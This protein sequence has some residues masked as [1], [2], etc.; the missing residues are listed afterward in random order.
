MSP[1]VTQSTFRQ[2]IVKIAGSGHR[3]VI[4]SL[5]AQGSIEKDTSPVPEVDE[6]MTWK[7][8]ASR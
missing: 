4:V 3:I 6:R 8:I 7:S 1:G 2:A 5:A